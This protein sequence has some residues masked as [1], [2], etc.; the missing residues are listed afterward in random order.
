MKSI[1]FNYTIKYLT[2][3]SLD[4]EDGNSIKIF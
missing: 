3:V 2:F 4:G 1:T